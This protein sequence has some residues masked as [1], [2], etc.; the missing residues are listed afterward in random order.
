M[1]KE[2]AIQ[3][4]GRIC[5]PPPPKIGPLCLAEREKDSDLSSVSDLEEDFDAPKTSSQKFEEVSESELEISEDDR[6]DRGD[7]R[8]DPPRDVLENIDSD[9]NDQTSLSS[10]SDDEVSDPSDLSEAVILRRRRL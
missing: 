4:S 8:A 3:S 6:R 2:N 10:I 7:R 9:E 1:S 5:P